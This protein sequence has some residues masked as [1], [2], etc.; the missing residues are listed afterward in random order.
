MCQ[1]AAILSKEQ[2]WR[3]LEEL[4]GLFPALYDKVTSYKGS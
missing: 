2:N 4:Y 1:Q 3:K